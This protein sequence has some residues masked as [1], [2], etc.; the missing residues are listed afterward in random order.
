MGR[1]GY[2]HRPAVA[3]NG[4]LIAVGWRGTSSG[5]VWYTVSNGS[6]WGTQVNTGQVT[7]YPPA[8]TALPSS[9]V[10]LAF[11]WTEPDKTEG[12][13]PQAATNVSPALGFAGNS[14]DGTLYVA[15]KGLT[16]DRIGYES[17]YNVAEST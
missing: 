15:W 13:I 7:S 6:G 1:G 4:S 12:T 11:A 10:P 14:S 16:N 2:Q 17:I 9:G 3:A 8:I 5:D